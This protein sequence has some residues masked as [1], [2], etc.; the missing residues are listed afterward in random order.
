MPIK[1]REALSGLML[2]RL[3][4][5]PWHHTN[6]G[7]DVQR[8]HVW[9]FETLFELL[10]E[11][12]PMSP[13]L[14]AYD[15]LGFFTYLL[16]QFS[17]NVTYHSTV[18]RYDFARPPKVKWVT[19]IV[20]MPPKHPAFDQKFKVIVVPTFFHDATPDK[21]ETL[22]PYLR[23]MCTGRIVFSYAVNLPKDAWYGNDRLEAAGFKVLSEV[24]EP[25]AL[26]TS[27]KDYFVVKSMEVV[28]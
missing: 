18:D 21:C 3:T 13:C 11:Q 6:S 26:R 24:C 10:R 28:K 25:G 17:E 23:R 14:C 19:D 5:I 27:T 8:E 12:K 1:F 16:T 9:R 7:I 2:D 4:L 15:T 20:H 22:L